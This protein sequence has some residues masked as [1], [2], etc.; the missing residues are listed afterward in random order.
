VSVTP[1]S[2]CGHARIAGCWRIVTPESA[3]FQFP[4]VPLTVISRQLALLS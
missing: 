3:K 1:L 2:H 4:D